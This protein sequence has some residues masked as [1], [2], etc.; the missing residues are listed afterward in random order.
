MFNTNPSDSRLDARELTN[1]IVNNSGGNK[2]NELHSKKLMI[3]QQTTLELNWIEA[4]TIHVLNVIFVVIWMDG[5]MDG[6]WKMECM[7]ANLSRI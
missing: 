4:S 6:W 3:L 2:I 7:I 5:W 1:L